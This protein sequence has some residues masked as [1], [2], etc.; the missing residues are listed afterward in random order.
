MKKNKKKINSVPCTNNKNN[1]NWKENRSFNLSVDSFLFV[2]AQMIVFIFVC[3]CIFFCSC[4][5]LICC[6]NE[7]ISILFNLQYFVH[8]LCRSQTYTF[9]QLRS[10]SITSFSYF[11]FIAALLYSRLFSKVLLSPSSISF[12]AY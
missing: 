1:E 6:I 2:V 8:R 9:F 11:L 5:H 10:H 4:L 7:F 12:L 3:T